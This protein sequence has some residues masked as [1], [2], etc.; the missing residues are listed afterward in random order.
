MRKSVFICSL[1][2]W[3]LR[4]VVS[5]VVFNSV[6]RVLADSSTKFLHIV[7]IRCY[8]ASSERVDWVT[9]SV[10]CVIVVGSVALD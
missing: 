6:R 3:I 7:M 10:C 4:N 2:S 8:S 9:A 1:L 5:A